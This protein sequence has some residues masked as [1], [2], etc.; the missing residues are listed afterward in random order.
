MPG[1]D[2]PAIMGAPGDDVFTGIP[3]FAADD[4]PVTEVG[5]GRNDGEGGLE[6]KGLASLDTFRSWAR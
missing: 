6:S 4:I 5:L 2:F 1:V 3:G